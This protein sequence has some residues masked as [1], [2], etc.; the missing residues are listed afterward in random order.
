MMKWGRT[1]KLAPFP[2]LIWAGQEIRY[3]PVFPSLARC[4][5][6]I[7]L[8]D[9]N[10]PGPQP[11]SSLVSPPLASQS[12]T[13][14]KVMTSHMSQVWP[15]SIPITIVSAGTANFSNELPDIA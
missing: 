10:F 7:K 2:Y 14:R 3:M 15:I 5:S 6:K 11:A 12:F 8:S 13:S 1:P 4:F 9:T